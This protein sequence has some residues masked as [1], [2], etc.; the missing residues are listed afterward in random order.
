MIIVSGPNDVNALIGSHV[1]IKCT[2][3][4][5][6]NQPMVRWRLSGAEYSPGTL[7]DR[8]NANSTGLSINPVTT[9]D[10]GLTVQ[11]YILVIDPPNI[12][13]H[14]SPIGVIIITTNETGK[15]SYRSDSILNPHQPRSNRLNALHKL[16]HMILL[17][18]L[19]LCSLAQHHCL[20]IMM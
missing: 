16:C 12:A 14:N 3:T 8:F 7:P 19:K 5:V 18:N 4:G 13:T 2:V 20:L 6:D 15:I 9:G 1:F 11:C 10:D 17:R